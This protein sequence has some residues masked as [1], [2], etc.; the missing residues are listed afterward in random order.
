MPE[1]FIIDDD[2]LKKLDEWMRSK[3]KK[4]TGAIGGRFTYSFH[5]TSLGVVVKVMDEVD[6][7]EIDLSDYEGW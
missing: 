6:R 5:P 7:D 4:Y 2:Q 3:P 1:T